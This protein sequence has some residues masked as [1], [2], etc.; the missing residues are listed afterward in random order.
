[1]LLEQ[2][3]VVLNH[4]TPGV[5][6]GL[7]PVTP[8]IEAP[9]E[10][11]W[12]GLAK[13]GHD[14]WRSGSTRPESAP[15][16]RTARS[17]APQEYWIARHRCAWTGRPWQPILL[18]RR[19]CGS[20][21]SARETHSGPDLSCNI[22]GLPCHNP[23]NDTIDVIGEFSPVSRRGGAPPPEKER[24]AGATNSAG[25]E[26]KSS[27]ALCKNV[28]TEN[29]VADRSVKSN[30]AVRAHYDHL[31]SN[32]DTT[33]SDVWRAQLAGWITED[34]AAELDALLRA[35]QAAISR[36]PPR[37]TQI[38]AKLTGG[39]SKLALGWP[40]RRPQRMPDR[41]KSRERARM[42]GGS[43]SLPPKVRAKYTLC[44]QAVLAIVGCEVKQRGRCDLAV[45]AIAAKAGVC[46]RTV[47]NAVAEAIRQRHLAREE[48]GLP[49]RKNDTNVLRITS[50]EWLTWIQH[51]P[52][53]VRQDGSGCKDYTATKTKDLSIG[54]FS[55]FQSETRNRHGCG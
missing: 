27:D 13:P 36:E 53:G 44:E 42:L 30:T 24:P 26:I 22:N 47:Q 19:H 51:A 20:A 9:C 17:E 15:A 10:T 39:K 21:A 12:G 50:K 11:K 43:S 35:Q 31:R 45:G 34:E 1:M 41:E 4:L 2:I 3:S 7:V 29:S 23:Q 25:P 8:K 55:Q 5:V 37:P 14:R 40:R 52:R 28:H 38:V 32:T 18:Y 6:A 48:R 16:C 33:I 49:G 46:V 54:D